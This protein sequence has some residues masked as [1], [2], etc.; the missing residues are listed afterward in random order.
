V[1]F[2]TQLLCSE[3]FTRR[4]FPRLAIL[5]NRRTG[6][7]RA[8]WLCYQ[9]GILSEGSPVLLTRAYRILCVP[10]FALEQAVRVD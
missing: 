6:E 1:F 8:I 10:D 9:A 5:R 7:Q 4:R 2:K 3:S